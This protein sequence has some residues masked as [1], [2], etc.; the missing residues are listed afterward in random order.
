MDSSEK[1]SRFGFLKSRVEAMESV[2][3]EEPASPNIGT[4]SPASAQ[5]GVTKFT[6]QG[7]DAGLRRAD[8][9][10]PTLLEGFTGRARDQENYIGAQLLRRYKQNPTPEGME[11]LMTHHDQV[12]GTTISKYAK[13]GLP[14]PAVRGKVYNAFSDA[15]QKYDFR[16]KDGRPPMQ[17]H[18]YF[19]ERA[20]QTPIERW[21]NELK[22]FAHVPADRARK[23]DLV[24]VAVEQYQLDH[25]RE[26]TVAELQNLTNGISASELRRILPELKTTGVSSRN[27]RA[28]FIVDE[29]ELWSRAVRN[30][31]DGFPAG[32]KERAVM[33]D[34]FAPVF[35]LPDV[36]MSKG[37]FAKKHGISASKLSKLFR[38]FRELNAAEMDRIQRDL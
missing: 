4:W 25:G 29:S 36:K 14:E 33:E 10:D 3:P 37:E 23:H 1:T 26:P 17:F 18:N 13:R 28:D 32:S 19:M 21:A 2:P 12:I 11:H 30:V 16:T 7:R 15:V 22:R 35:G 8:Y 5:A 38:R 31:R 20:V 6:F 9:S 27:I 34:F 24:R